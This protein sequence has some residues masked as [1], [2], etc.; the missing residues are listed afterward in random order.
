MNKKHY[1]FIIVFSYLL[2][3]IATI[4]VGTIIKTIN[5]N[6]PVDIHGASGT[7]WNGQAISISI[8]QMIQLDNTEWSFTAWKLLIG[9]AAYQINSHYDKKT[10]ESEVG[11]SFL[12]QYFINDFTAKMTAGKLAKL[13]D[14]PLVQLSGDITFNIDHAYWKKDTL[15]LAIGTITWD[16]AAIT[17]ADTVALGKVTIAL[18]ESDEQLLNAKINNKGG[19]ILVDGKVE[20]I[21]EEKYSADIKLSPT[22]SANGNIKNSLSLFAKKQKNGDFLLKKTG[23][24]NQLGFQ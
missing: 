24:L 3:L 10:I 11:S 17:V 20:L 13:A 2:F 23:Q 12:G 14:I 19:D 16:T 8:N 4:P 15:P 21:P 6:T 5:T 7:I 9:Q 1:F 18:S 22:S